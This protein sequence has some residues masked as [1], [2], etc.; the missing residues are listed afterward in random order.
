ME[1]V[2]RCILAD[3]QLSNVL[4]EE[5]RLKHKYCG[6][7]PTKLVHVALRSQLA[8]ELLGEELKSKHKYHGKNRIENP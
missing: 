6:T 8:K 4:G 7:K 2:E 3:T 5:L 1:K